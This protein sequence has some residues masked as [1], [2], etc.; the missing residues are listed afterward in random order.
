MHASRVTALVAVLILA[1]PMAFAKEIERDF[2]R[3]F[4]VGRGDRLHLA[5]GD[6]DVVI[7]PW[8]R[9][10]LDVEV[11]FHAEYTR[12]GLGGEVDFDVDFRQSGSTVHVVGRESGWA[13][14]GFFR[15]LEHEYCYTVRAP[16]YLLLDLTGD[17]GDV[18]IRDWEGDVAIHVEDGDVDLAGIRSAR[19]ELRID[20]GD[21]MIEG[22]EGRLTVEGED[23]EL[24]LSDCSLTESRIQ[25]DDGDVLLS[26]C[27]GGVRIDV[28]DGD[29]VLERFLAHRLEVESDDGDVDLDL[30]R[31][32]DLDV[33]VRTADGDVDVALERGSSAAF[34]IDTGDGS[35]QVDLPEAEDLSRRRG[36]ASG[37]VGGGAGKLH[38]TT[39]DGR[40]VLHEGS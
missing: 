35:I 1:A 17:D 3:S 9:D 14:I 40:V 36:R 8:E 26:R 32:G 7:E 31:S 34:T 37:R 24:R 21:V 27:E 23:G 20:D 12:I 19:V 33:L 16:S 5:H 29:V 39:D 25:L 22:L 11:R 38:V 15:Y 10:V 30:M 13:S 18:E 2:H 6:G 28:E 4:E